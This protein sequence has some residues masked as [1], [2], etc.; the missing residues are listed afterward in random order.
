MDIAEKINLLPDCVRR[1]IFRA[2]CADSSGPCPSAPSGALD[3][4]KT[5][6]N[7]N[8]K[9][10]KGKS[11]A[12]IPTL[13]ACHQ[14]LPVVRMVAGACIVDNFIT[15][16]H[17]KEALACARQALAEGQ[18]HAA[19]GGALPLTSDSRHVDTAA[20]GDIMRWLHAERE[21]TAGRGP[22]AALL[23]Q[24]ETLRQQLEQQGYSVAG[25]TT[26]QLACY[27]GNGTRYVRHADAS[28]SCPTRTLTAIVYLNEA[29]W[30][31]QVD[32]G[33]LA[34]YNVPYS[35]PLFGCGLAAGEPAT[36][37]AP[38]GGRLVVFESHLFH[39]VLPAHRNRYA[40]TAW[41][42]KPQPQPPMGMQDA[43]GAE[44]TAASLPLPP[45]PVS[46][47]TEEPSLDASRGVSGPGESP[48][49]MFAD[50]VK[51]A[52]R[53]MPAIATA[54]AEGTPGLQ[55]A[56]SAAVN[57][58]A[59]DMAAADASTA[60][61]A[62]P[63]PA[64]IAV[65]SVTAEGDTCGQIDSVR[66]RAGAEPVTAAA[67]R[68]SIFVSMAA[69]R[70]PEG[71]WTLHSLFSKAEHP[72][73]V[74]VG[75]VWQIDPVTEAG[76]VGVAGARTHPEWLRQI[77]QIVVPHQDAKGPCTARAQAQ[78]LW[79][80]EEYVLQI[81]SHMRMVSGWDT[82]CIQQ[83]AAAEAM[84]NSGKAVLSTYPLGYSGAGPAA[85]SPDDTSAP[86]TLLCAKGFE[87]DGF[88]RTVGR[89]LRKRPAAPLPTHFWAAGLT[90]TRSAWLREVPYCPYLPHL[91]FGEESYM[92]AR[93]WTRGWDVF[94]PAVPLAFHQWER[95]ARAH[96]CQRDMASEATIRGDHM[97][98]Q[99]QQQQPEQQPEQQ[100]QQQGPEQG[101]EEGQGQVLWQGATDG[102][103]MTGTLNSK[104]A[105]EV[106]TACSEAQGTDATIADV[107]IASIRKCSQ[108]HVL[109]VLSGNVV[110]TAA[111]LAGEPSGAHSLQK[112]GICHAEVL[113]QRSSS[114]GGGIRD[115]EGGISG[116][117]G[118]G[119]L[120][121]L[122]TL[123]TLEQL[124]A[125]SG[126]DYTA[127]TVS[128][129][130]QWGGLSQ[131]AFDL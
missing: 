41:F 130:A 84:S 32:G 35:G 52:E 78:T 118:L 21:A 111:V 82:L 73:R 51:A 101:M 50:S 77:S 34:L 29:D 2:V 129:R 89:V 120:W 39:E 26:Y 5:Q 38:V 36:V 75:V 96:P 15:Q 119:Q 87:Q 1:Q 103:W 90:F 66:V 70:D 76:F 108:A 95:S 107:T 80:G 54:G 123:R 7:I 94:A 30:D 65:S 19:I 71:R 124:A 53:R 92:L 106:I 46:Y 22:L 61:N 55:A 83:L 60:L 43:A 67:V 116:G 110:A 93:M 62:A 4:R 57:V 24:M 115:R 20:R 109:R 37:V 59:G 18:Q 12:R 45:C 6:N 9:L 105:N 126:V 72:E 85:S 97:P 74:R 125:A 131:D 69:Y 102:A 3:V 121:G 47:N 81:D 10:Q 117:W 79:S 14:A 112:C 49:R 122:G 98:G 27:P 128:A 86:A 91:F 8:N 48:P 28:L 63:A 42:H 23:G 11:Q 33:C 100:G 31:T 56:A 88:L 64:P 25:C 127:K 58:T 17:T 16:D 113:A 104:V 13:P 44:P 99:Q 114:L 40:V 68:A